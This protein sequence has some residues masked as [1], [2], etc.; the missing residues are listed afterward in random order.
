[1]RDGTRIGIAQMLRAGITC[2]ASVGVHPREIA[3]QAGAARMHAAIGLPV[4]EDGPLADAASLWDEFRSSPWTSPYFAPDALP[5]LSDTTLSRV[6]TIADELDARIALP[7]RAADAACATER[8]L[9]RLERLGLLR[10]GF[11]ALDLT[12]SDA[13]DLELAARTAIAAVACPQADL[14]RGRGVALLRELNG[15]GVAL[16]LGS[17]DLDG[18]LDLLA[19]ARTAALIGAAP[20]PAPPLSASTVLRLATLGGAAVLGL[21]AE[22][23]SIEPGKAADLIALDLGALSSQSGAQ[24][25]ESI[26]FSATREHVSDVWL[27]GSAAVARGRLL[28]FDTEELEALRERWREQL[29]LPW[30]SPRVPAHVPTESRA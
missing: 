5:H 17:G 15:R 21:A 3:R 4:G 28:A 2:F 14:L 1:V 6:R 24:P 22:I 25:A 29:L 26:V 12:H 30:S 27:S 9:Q 7:L 16:A 19:E 20:A 18:A 13:E 23:G 10:P 8:P 11:V